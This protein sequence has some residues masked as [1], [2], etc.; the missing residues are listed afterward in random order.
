[1]TTPILA[2]ALGCVTENTFVE[3]PFESIAVVAGD[4]DQIEQNLNRLEVA[5]S[6]YEGFIE[7]PSYD[8]SVDPDLIALK[9]ESLFTAMDEDGNPELFIHDAVFVNSGAR[10]FGA[11]EYQGLEEDDHLVGDEQVVELLQDYVERGRTVMVSD[12]AYDLIEAAWPDMIDFYGEDEDLDA[13]QVGVA[14]RVAGEVVGLD[15]GEAIGEQMSIEMNYSHWALIEDVHPDVVVHVQGD[16]VYR[17]SASEGEDTATG[18]P[19][20]VSFPVGAG[21]VVFSSFHW[22]AQTA[23]ASDAA[24][25][26]LIPGLDPG[27]AAADQETTTDE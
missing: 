20:L 23:G 16:V 8:D 27:N 12:W 17:K 10:G 11:Y 2:L 24:M 5:Y 18:V 21:Q 22:N 13:A 7:G 25:V 1:M 15:L 14:G 26:A 6:T 19:L 3:Q 9:S 4:F